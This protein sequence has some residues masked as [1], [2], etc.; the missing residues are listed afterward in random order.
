VSGSRLTVSAVPDDQV[1]TE[2]G[3]WPFQGRLH[4][5]VAE[6]HV[7]DLVDGDGA[8]FGAGE[9]YWAAFTLDA[10]GA[11]VKGVR[12]TEANVAATRDL[13]ALRSREA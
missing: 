10:S 13:S 12:A 4:G 8:A 11:R 5:K 6:D 7:L 9:S 3:L 1:H 2:A